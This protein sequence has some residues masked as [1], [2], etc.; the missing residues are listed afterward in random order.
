M[1]FTRDRIQTILSNESIT[2]G[3]KV[4][5]IFAMHGQT[6]SDGYISRKEAEAMKQD[7]VKGVQIPDPKESDVYKALDAEFSAYKTKQA[8]RLSDEYKGVKPKFFDA[9]YDAVD[10]KEGAKPITEQIAKIKEEY[11]EY[12][13]EEEEKRAPVANPTFGTPTEGAMPKGGANSFDSYWGFAKN[14]KE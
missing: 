2:I 5:Q 6:L 7:A 1:A 9:V 8:A 13:V 14:K 12:F 4:D 11:S 10:R 3:E